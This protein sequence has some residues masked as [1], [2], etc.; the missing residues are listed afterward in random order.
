[1][2]RPTPAPP[3]SRLHAPSN[4]ARPPARH[5]CAHARLLACAH[6]GARAGGRRCVE[7]FKLVESGKWQEEGVRALLA[8]PAQHAGC[9]AARKIPDNLSDLR[10]QDPRPPRRASRAAPR[11]GGAASISTFP[12]EGAARDARVPPAGQV[13]ANQKGIALVADLIKECATC[14]ACPLPPGPTPAPRSQAHLHAHFLEVST[15]C[16]PR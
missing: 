14:P 5:A 8:S 7:S 4:L 9:A 3:P 16:E 6:K 10:A 15:C 11:R 2:S 12:R 1:M 13:A